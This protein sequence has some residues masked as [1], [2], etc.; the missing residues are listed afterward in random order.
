MREWV[1]SQRRGGMLDC[2]YHMICK[3]VMRIEGLVIATGDWWL[4][5]VGQESASQ[6]AGYGGNGGNGGGGS[7][8]G[9]GS[10]AAP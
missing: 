10:G 8:G 9:S 3:F 5:L 4:D 2:F 7:S 1:E 6:A